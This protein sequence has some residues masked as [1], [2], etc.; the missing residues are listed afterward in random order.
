MSKFPSPRDVN[1]ASTYPEQ[2]P[3]SLRVG[4]LIHGGMGTGMPA[5]GPILTSQ[6]M[7]EL[8]SYLYSFA[9]QKRSQGTN[10]VHSP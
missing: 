1:S 7:D 9:L 10:A 4:M 8:I 6:Q 3:V 2:K 5:W